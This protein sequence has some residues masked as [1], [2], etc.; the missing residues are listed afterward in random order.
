MKRLLLLVTEGFVRIGWDDKW[1]SGKESELA[2]FTAVGSTTLQQDFH[3]SLVLHVSFLVAGTAHALLYLHTNIGKTH[4]LISNT[5]LKELTFWRSLATLFSYI[6]V[7]SPVLGHLSMHPVSSR[8][9][10]SHSFNTWCLRTSWKHW[11]L[12]YGLY[13]LNSKNWR[14]DDDSL[15]YCNFHVFL[16]YKNITCTCAHPHTHSHMDTWT[17]TRPILAN[18]S[19]KATSHWGGILQA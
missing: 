11:T 10:L 6:L 9:P 2:V 1:L 5:A 8:Y 18:T 19:L 7:S 3:E 14:R 16:R 13:F 17:L 4:A 12:F 15:L